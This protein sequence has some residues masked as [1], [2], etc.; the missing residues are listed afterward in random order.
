MDISG[1][2]ARD[3]G[4][5]LHAYLLSLQYVLRTCDFCIFQIIHY[6]T[7][8]WPDIKYNFLWTNVK[9]YLLCKLFSLSLIYNENCIFVLS[10]NV[11]SF[12][13]T[14]F[15]LIFRFNLFFYRIVP[16]RNQSHLI[17]MINLSRD[18]W[19]KTFI[20]NLFL[21]LQFLF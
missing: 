1:G 16:F 6:M 7:H 10:N 18:G 4:F 11:I 5:F 8:C 12:S 21:W 19:D 14:L 15:M 2:C 13:Y 9:N 20:L 3:I 17:S